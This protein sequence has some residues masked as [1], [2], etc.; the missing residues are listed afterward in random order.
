LYFL[1]RDIVEINNQRFLACTLWSNPT[2]ASGLNDFRQIYD[3]VSDKRRYPIEAGTMRQWHR[4]DIAWLLEN[5][6]PDDIVITHFM[7]CKNY[8]LI[9][10]G[11][12]SIYPISSFDDYFGNDDC[13]PIFERKPKLWIS[14]H[15]HQSFDVNVPID[16]D[17]YVQWVCN[18]Y[19]YPDEDTGRHIIQDL[20]K[21]NE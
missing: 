19:G 3:Q 12:D 21:I 20:I 18:P 16:N 14:G 8:D 10:Y 4:R 1:D 13:M 6:Q 2:S 5:V 9:L 7:P 15:T 11:H 17:L